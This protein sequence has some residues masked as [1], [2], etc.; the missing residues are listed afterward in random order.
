[1][2][3]GVVKPSNQIVAYGDPLMVEMEIG[4]NATAAEMKAGRVIIFDDA[5]QTVKESGAAAAN[6]VGFL[7]VDP[8]KTKS[9]A[10][11]VG[12]QAK[13]VIGEC[14]A[15]LTL[16][17]NESVTRGDALVTAA[18]GKLAKQAVGAMGAQGQVVA[19][20]WESSNVAQDAEILVHWK[21]SGEPAAAA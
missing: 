19:Y 6:V 9:T 10:Y 1:M 13:V 15:V 11:A 7:E 18:N 12:D 2:P 21:P 17:A 8:A 5:D 3:Q 16:L 20:A 14:L 4:A